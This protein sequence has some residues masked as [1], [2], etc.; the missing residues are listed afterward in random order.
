[1]DDG[2]APR[3]EIEAQVLRDGMVTAQGEV[4]DLKVAPKSVLNDLTRR[5]NVQL[6]LNVQH[7]REKSRST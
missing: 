3:V 5:V 1:M 4:M 6:E 7:G 2:T